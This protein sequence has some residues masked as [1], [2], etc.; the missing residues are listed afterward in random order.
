M[1]FP[2]INREKLIVFVPLSIGTITAVTLWFMQ[3]PVHVVD[4]TIM[5]SNALDPHIFITYTV[6]SIILSAALV[7]MIY[8]LV[9]WCKKE[10]F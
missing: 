7:D 3:E 6:L 2:K 1:K 5:Y 9:G 10:C 4:G 8:W